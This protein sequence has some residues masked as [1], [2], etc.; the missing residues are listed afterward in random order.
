MIEIFYLQ[1][2]WIF[3]RWNDIR[4]D[5]VEDISKAAAYTVAPCS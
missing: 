3:A 5:L 2:E 4:N 1:E